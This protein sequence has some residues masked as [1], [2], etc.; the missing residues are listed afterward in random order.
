MNK[1]PLTTFSLDVLEPVVK[2]DD[3]CVEV[4]INFL[5]ILSGFPRRYSI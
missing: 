2:D 3:H 4:F 1:R 5:M